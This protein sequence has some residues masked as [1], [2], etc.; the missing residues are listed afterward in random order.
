MKRVISILLICL[1]LLLSG[2]GYSESEMK[3]IKQE[4]Y[5]DGFLAGAGSSDDS[6][7]SGHDEGYDEGYDD[8]WYAAIHEMD[9]RA[10]DED[11][12]VDFAEYVQSRLD[13]AFDSLSDYGYYNNEEYVKI[14]NEIYRECDRRLKAN[15]YR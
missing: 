4:A 13:Y 6:Y 1:A 7:S 5:D 12:Q 9:E 10:K 2:C 8:G 3:R 11:T 15:P 14:L